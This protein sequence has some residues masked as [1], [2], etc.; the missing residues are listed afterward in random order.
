V[1]VLCGGT[2][3]RLIG[4]ATG[5]TVGHSI[6]L[7][8]ASL[9]LIAIPSRVVESLIALSIVYLALEAV[10]QKTP[11]YRW[12]IASF[13][14]L[15]H[16]LGFATAIRDLNLSGAT[17]INALVG[18]NVGVELGQAVIIVILAPVF[19]ALGKRPKIFR[20]VQIVLS[21]LIFLVGS[22]WFIQRAFNL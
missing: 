20:P 7:A 6:T 11:K 4:T 18:F 22:F 10:I 3:W 9:N 14:G 1:L 8:A 17:L 5:F 13:F 12:A 2:L 21:S 19:F 15:I 16:G